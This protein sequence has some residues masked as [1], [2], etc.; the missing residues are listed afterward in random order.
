MTRPPTRLV[1]VYGTLRRGEVRDINRLQPTPRWVGQGSVAGLL[2]DLGD[3]PGLLLTPD[4]SDSRV[5][6]EVYDVAPELERQLDVIEEVWP[7]S[8]GEYVRREVPV[9]MDVEPGNRDLGHPQELICLLY[10]ISPDRITRK[11]VI[12]H[13]DWVRRVSSRAP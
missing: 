9:W 7:Q 5:H 11:P 4:A 1:F 12:A 2:Y 13:G 10:E 8:T 3:Y 6:G